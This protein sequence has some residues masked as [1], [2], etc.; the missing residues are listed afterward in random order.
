MH[1]AKLLVLHDGE[2]YN[3]GS[4][5][6]G[7]RSHGGEN[8][9]RHP[10]VPAGETANGRIRVPQSHHHVDTECVLYIDYSIRLVIGF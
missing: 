10:H 5:P 9:S 8:H 4:A 6:A 1:I 7:R 3:D 2:T